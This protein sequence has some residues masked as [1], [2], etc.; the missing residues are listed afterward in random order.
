MGS[1]PAN[2]KT[3][4]ADADESESGT[5]SSA[6]SDSTGPDEADS[7]IDDTE[8]FELNVLSAAFE[9][10]S[11]IDKY[12]IL[13]RANHDQLE[14]LEET[15]VVWKHHVELLTTAAD[16]SQGSWKKEERRRERGDTKLIWECYVGLEARVSQLLQHLPVCVE[17]YSK[18]NGWDF[19]SLRFVVH[20]WRGVLFFIPKKIMMSPR[21]TPFSSFDETRH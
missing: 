18:Q 10:T 11:S 13:V 1:G 17:T 14:R 5:E 15:F 7:P 6:S 21:R 12:D 4:S 8:N 19:P 3:Y 2:A 9:S 16:Q 20:F